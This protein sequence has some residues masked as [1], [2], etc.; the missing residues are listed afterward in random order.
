MQPA[1]QQWGT[2]EQG[3]TQQELSDAQQLSEPM[4]TGGDMGASVWRLPVFVGSSSGWASDCSY[5]VE[6][7][8]IVE[9]HLTSIKADLSAGLAAG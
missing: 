4:N 8:W 2:D 5:W 9:N 7:T 1:D 3:Q 6:V